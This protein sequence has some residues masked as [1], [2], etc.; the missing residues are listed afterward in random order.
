MCLETLRMLEL[1][2]SN[3]NMPSGITDEETNASQ[4]GSDLPKVTSKFLTRTR[5][6]EFYKTGKTPRSSIQLNR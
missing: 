5:K 3:V 4:R 2:Q 6:D 1:K